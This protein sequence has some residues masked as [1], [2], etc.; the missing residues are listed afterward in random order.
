VFDRGFKAWSE[1]VATQQRRALGLSATSPLDPLELAAR[2]EIK[3]FKPEKVPGLDA[4]SL[5]VL[6]HD[7]PESWSAL[8]VTVGSACA[9]VL[10]SVHSGGRPASDLMHELAH[11]LA[12]HIPARLDITSDGL[13]ILNTYDK[14]QEEEAAWLAGA[15]LL[16]RVALELIYRQR[17]DPSEAAERYGI[18]LSMFQYRVR[19]TGIERQFPRRRVAR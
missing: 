11:I 6:L 16:P 15:L 7:D 13:L 17:V 19:M 9:I 3:V 10:N 2:L 5:R 14:Q 18:S 1:N 8:T 12:N 4:E